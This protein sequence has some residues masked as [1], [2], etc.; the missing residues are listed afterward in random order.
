M[1]FTCLTFSLPFKGLNMSHK[2]GGWTQGEECA[3]D[4]PCGYAAT[5]LATKFVIESGPPLNRS[6]QY[7]V[8]PCRCA[9]ASGSTGT[10]PTASRKR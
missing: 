1:I 7:R 5:N 10:A 6:R 2:L 3:I 8:G 4:R 9:S